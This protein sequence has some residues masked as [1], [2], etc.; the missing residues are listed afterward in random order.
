[1]R[2]TRTENHG[3]LAHIGKKEVTHLKSDKI[4][5]SCGEGGI[6]GV[7]G[8]RHAQFNTQTNGQVL[9]NIIINAWTTHPSESKL[10][11]S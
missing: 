1:M 7:C 9:D 11:T 2:L 5:R 10:P 8:I 3:N 6:G 4:N